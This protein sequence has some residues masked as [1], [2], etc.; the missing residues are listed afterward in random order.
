MWY[1]LQ[2]FTILFIDFPVV[3]IKIM[4]TRRVMNQTMEIVPSYTR[5]SAFMNF[6]RQENILGGKPIGLHVIKPAGKIQYSFSTG[7]HVHNRP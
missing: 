4:Y 6:V 7:F 1:P 5:F 3:V 2:L